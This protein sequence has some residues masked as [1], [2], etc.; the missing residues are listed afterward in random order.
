[1]EEINP[2]NIKTA[3][4]VVGV[5]SYNEADTIANVVKKLDQGLEKYFKGRKAVI[6]NADNN[7]SD[8][9]RE[10]FL[11]TK[12]KT[13]KIYVST[14]PGV[15][16][17]G[18]NLRNI[19]LKVKDLGALYC[20][21]V[22][23]DIKNMTPEWVKCLLNP[24]VKGYDY[25]S[26]IYYRDEDDGSITNHICFPLAYGLLGYNIRQPIA[27]E[28]G[29]SRALVE[30]WLKQKWSAEIRKFGIDIFMILNAIQGKFKLCRV[31]LG[32]KV[33]KPSAPKL[34]FMFLVGDTK[35]VA[36]K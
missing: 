17:K 6:I 7:S 12:T 3:E 31:N 35:I 13:P 33:H 32:S 4:I 21:I 30:Y 27:G 29:F 11:N 34:D 14:P 26:P 28:V 24:L 23:S 36:I 15:S 19:F 2:D 25:I 8:N 9:T 10:V 22:D 20:M 1:M 18:N 5:P 16:G